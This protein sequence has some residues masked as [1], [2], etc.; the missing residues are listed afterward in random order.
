MCN[1]QSVASLNSHPD[2]VDL[3]IGANHEKWVPGAVVGPVSVCLFG[4]QF[5]QL[6]YGD[7]FFFTHEGQFTPG[8]HGPSLTRFHRLLSRS[9]GLDQKVSVPLLLLPHHRYR[10]ST[11]K[12]L[13]TTESRKVS[14]RD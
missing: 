12:S 3:L 14:H 5:R 8:K 2:D 11:V 13:P 7:R 6:K 10:P 1:D 9:N 4:I